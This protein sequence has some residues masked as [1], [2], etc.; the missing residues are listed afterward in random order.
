MKTRVVPSEELSPKTLRAKDYMEPEA[1]DAPEEV[2]QFAIKLLARRWHVYLKERAKVLPS[3]KIGELQEAF[4]HLMMEVE[5]GFALLRKENKEL[6]E[7]RDRYK[8][9]A[10]NTQCSRCG[11]PMGEL[12]CLP[13]QDEME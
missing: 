7:E 10:A 12:I 5:D 9:A 3:A 4:N 13:C 6:C 1:L 8:N 2:K 11:G